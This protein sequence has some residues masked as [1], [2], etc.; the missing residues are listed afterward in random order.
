M[1]SR[2]VKL[3]ALYAVMILGAAALY[4]LVRSYGES[5]IP[6]QPATL[7]ASP[8]TA[9][10]GAPDV[11]LHVLL[12]LVVVIVAARAV[13]SLFAF[14]HQPP[15]VGEIL[16]GILLG[17]SLLGRVA[18]GISAYLFSSATTP[19]LGVIAELGVVLYMFLVGLELDPSLLKRRGHAAVS[20][21]HASI[22]VPFLSGAILALY[23]YP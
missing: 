22:V 14:F 1:N 4:L 15:V 5:L 16:A 6:L 23:L 10:T 18:P 20:I 17:P 19:F 12:A 2:N 13:G 7:F 9:R 11:M 21:S 8:G 3:A